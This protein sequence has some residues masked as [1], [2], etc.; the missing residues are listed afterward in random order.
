MVL[1]DRLNLSLI[2]L[3]G[4]DRPD[5]ARFKEKEIELHGALRQ[6]LITQTLRPQKMQ[7]FNDISR[8]LNAIAD[9]VLPACPSCGVLLRVEDSAITK[10]DE[11]QLKREIADK[12]QY[13]E[14]QRYSIKQE[15]DRMDDCL[16]KESAISHVL[17]Q[18]Q[19]KQAETSAQYDKAQ[20]DLIEQ[21][22]LQ[23]SLEQRRIQYSTELATLTDIRQKKV[24]LADVSLEILARQQAMKQRQQVFKDVS[25]IYSSTGAMAYIL[26]SIVES[27]NELVAEYVGTLWPNTTYRLNSSR[28]NVDGQVVAKFSNT[29][30]INGKTATIGSLSGGELRALSLAVDF[31]LIETLSRYFSISVNPLILDEAFNGL[32]SVGRELITTILEKMSTTRQIWVIDHVTEAKTMFKQVIHVEKRNSISSISPDV[33]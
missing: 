10:V 9:H 20:R 18:L 28:E 19:E 30:I 17:K 26:D 23:R 29:L 33:I 24:Q 13:L 22:G 6:I 11:E 1:L 3:S 4:I 16:L 5:L 25:G 32:D 8:E 27:F 15:L 7:E 14:Q 31:A 12:K 2:A 21:R